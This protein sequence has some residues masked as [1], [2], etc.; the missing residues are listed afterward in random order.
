MQFLSLAESQAIDCASMSIHGRFL[1]RITIHAWRVLL[2]IAESTSVKVEN[3]SQIQIINWIEADAQ[4]R[5][6]GGSAFLEWDSDRPDLGFDDP[7]QD[8]VSESNLSSHEKFLTRMIVSA[9]TTLCQIAQDCGCNIFDLTSDRLIS[10]IEKYQQSTE[11]SA[12]IPEESLGELDNV[13][14]DQSSQS[15]KGI[16]LRS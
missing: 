11:I 5:R 9:Q 16:F 3:L 4:I 15:A 12:E 14:G 7:I 13:L 2:H 6:Q 1:T 8:L 10:W